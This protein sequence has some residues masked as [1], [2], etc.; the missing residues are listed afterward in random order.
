MYIFV[1]VLILKSLFLREALG[2]LQNLADS[3]ESSHSPL[4]P[5]H[6]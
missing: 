1:T 3:T 4:I 6:V 2:S 5:T